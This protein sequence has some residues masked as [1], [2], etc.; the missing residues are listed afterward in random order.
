MRCSLGRSIGRSI[1][2][3]LGGLLNR[4]ARLNVLHLVLG[5]VIMWSLVVLARGTGRRAEYFNYGQCRSQCNRAPVKIQ[6]DGCMAQCNAAR[7]IAEEVKRRPPQL[8]T[9]SDDANC[10]LNG[11]LY[12]KT[13]DTDAEHKPVPGGIDKMVRSTYHYYAP[14]YETSPLSCADD[15]HADKNYG[16]K[17][18]KYPWFAYCATP[19]DRRRHCGRCFK[20]TNPRNKASIVARAVDQCG[21]GTQLD[22]DGCAFRMI[23]DGAGVAKGAMQLRMQE[24]NCD[25]SA[26]LTGTEGGNDKTKKPAPK[27]PKQGKKPK[28]TNNKKK[29]R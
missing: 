14:Q 4:F 6:R 23:D 3:W 9:G 2:R 15:I 25:P 26:V 13:K 20:L 24:V 5:G 29:G 7:D 18:L 16:P 27:K 28:K 11:T 10:N 21:E 17:M 12:K 19:F 8:A 22:L 1:G